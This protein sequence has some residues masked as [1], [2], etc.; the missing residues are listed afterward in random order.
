MNMCQGEDKHTGGLMVSGWEGGRT[1]E[2]WWEDPGPRTD[3]LASLRP[4]NFTLPKND[5]RTH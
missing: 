3:G 2:Y 5:I 1:G 4:E